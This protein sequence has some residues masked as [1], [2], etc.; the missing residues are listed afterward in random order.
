[1]EREDDAFDGLIETPDLA[2]AG[3]KARLDVPGGD[4]LAVLAELDLDGIR[5]S[6]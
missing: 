3:E 5:V 6:C 4:A 2:D 1:V